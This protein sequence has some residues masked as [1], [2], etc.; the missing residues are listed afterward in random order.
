MHLLALRVGRRAIL[1]ELKTALS[2]P[3]ERATVENV[4]HMF[5]LL[6]FNTPHQPHHT[7]YFREAAAGAGLDIKES[8]L[9]DEVVAGCVLWHPHPSTV[10]AF[11]RS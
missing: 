1:E 10:G 2:D 3:I 4:Y 6:S 5:K 7:A 8:F 9:A 11:S